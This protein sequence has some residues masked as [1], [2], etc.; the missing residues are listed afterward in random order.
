[1]LILLGLIAGLS[2]TEIMVEVATIALIPIA[3]H[4]GRFA[5]GE[6]AKRAPS[7]PIAVA[8]ALHAA[9][10]RLDRMRGLR[11]VVTS[12]CLLRCR[13][14][15]AT[16][17]EEEP[18]GAWPSVETL[19]Q[20]SSVDCDL[21]QFCFRG[22]VSVRLPLASLAPV[23]GMLPDDILEVRGLGRRGEPWARC[24]RIG[25][26]IQLP[27]RCL[28]GGSLSD[29]SLSDGSLSGGSLSGGSLAGDSPGPQANSIA[30]AQLLR[31]GHFVAEVGQIA[32]AWA[33]TPKDLA[34]VAPFVV[35]DAARAPRTYEQL[36]LGDNTVVEVHA[37]ATNLA[38]ETVRVQ[39]ATKKHIEKHDNPEGSAFPNPRSAPL[40]S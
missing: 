40:K 11:S 24:F 15:D 5:A 28:V 14:R 27:V 1:M 37:L 22:D 32:R 3:R 33:P 7:L 30:N 9:R 26:D 31:D 13:P 19:L 4:A 16:G 36:F 10:F 38:V 2:M 17:I 25:D 23:I 8:M 39:L 6:I 18:A 21:A 35:R 12:T 34:R 29:G 20:A